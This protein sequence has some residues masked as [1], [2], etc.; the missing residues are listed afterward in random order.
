MSKDL[1]P[2]VVTDRTLVIKLLG[3]DRGFIAALQQLVHDG[4]ELLR[5]HRL[6]EV[7]IRQRLCCLEALGN[8]SGAAPPGLGG[9]GLSPWD[10]PA[11]VGIPR[12]P[13]GT[14]ASSFF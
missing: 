8:D 13:V 4:D 3:L 11:P 1:A 7:E 5:I 9:M 10:P 12:T 6:L 14:T 2:D